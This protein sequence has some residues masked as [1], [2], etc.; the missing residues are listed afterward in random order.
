MNREERR[1][2]G[3]ALFCAIY[4]EFESS[5][6]E[7]EQF[8]IYSR[9]LLC[10]SIL[11]CESLCGR[12]HN[13]SHRGQTKGEIMFAPQP[14]LNGAEFSYIYQGSH[15]NCGAPPLFSTICIM[16]QPAF[17]QSRRV[18]SPPSSLP[19]GLSLPVDRPRGSRGDHDKCATTFGQTTFAQLGITLARGSNFEKSKCYELHS[20]SST[21]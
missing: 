19:L 10:C 7:T 2:R 21:T 15:E 1:V 17:A 18:T 5:E 16:S 3:Y 20:S 8:T 13:N 11:P 6:R 12:A 14:M 9:E 4:R